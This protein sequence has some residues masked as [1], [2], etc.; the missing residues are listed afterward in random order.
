MPGAGPRGEV[1][2][3]M[4]VRATNAQL[5]LH[6]RFGTAK[7]RAGIGRDRY[8][9]E[10]GLYR[11]GDPGRDAPV[12]VTS[13]YKLTFDHV[14]SQLA[15]LDAW[16]LV[17]DTKGINVWCAAGKNTFGTVELS[18]RVIDAGLADLV[19]HRTLVVPQLGATG[20]AAHDVRAFTG[21]RVV[22]GPVRATDLRAYLAGGMKAT[23][24][25]RRVTFTLRERL[26]LVPVEFSLLWQPRILAGA[27]ALVAL[28]GIGVWGFSAD[29]LLARGPAVLIAGL[30]GWA[31]GALLTPA[32]LPW[33]PGRA[34]SL[35][36]ALV[37]LLVAVGLYAGLAPGIGALAA[38]ALALAAIAIASYA[39]MNFTGATPFTSLSG[40]LHEMRRA[41]PW[42]I[43]AA[44]VAAV[45]WVASAFLGKGW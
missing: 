26:V 8:A 37:G 13:N 43:A 22:F 12:L 33:I 27:A 14:R 31:A 11:V 44:G 6:D 15:G 25:M 10:P 4:D 19:D 5:T 20:V 39:A 21:F 23:P 32:L 24:P 18:R 41:L 1:T 28:S 17:L 29:A 36:G 2:P 9:V 45:V 42:Q 40:V 34:F 16:L 30:S 35:K 3:S 7:V 38:A